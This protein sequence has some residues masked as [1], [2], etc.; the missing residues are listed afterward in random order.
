MNKY[1][2]IIFIGCL[3]YS[4][5]Q[6]NA[7]LTAVEKMAP[8]K[9]RN[10]FNEIKL[11]IEIDEKNLNVISQKKNIPIAILKQFIPDSILN[12]IN[13]KNNKSIYILPIGKIEK[14]SEWYLIL[15]FVYNSFK[16]V[17]VFAF[18]KKNKF[19]TSLL[20]N[21][22]HNK[23]QIGKY[24]VQINKEPTFNIKEKNKIKNAQNEMLGQSLAFI[25]KK[26][27]IVLKEFENPI[28]SKNKLENPID[29]FLDL[30]T[31]SADYF[32]DNQLLSLRDGSDKNSYTFYLKLN[33]DN[34]N[35]T[36]EITG[37][38]K[39]VNNMSQ[40]KAKGDPCGLSFKFNKDFIKIQEV[41]QC[42]SKRNF[43][44]NFNGIYYKKY[45]KKRLHL[46]FKLKKNNKSMK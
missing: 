38:I 39:L 37:D 23:K 21:Q 31:Y 29:T 40:F 43:V 17:Y 18:D 12:L 11:P 14:E 7:N 30:N 10:L 6:D 33:N 19:V 45:T 34:K 27:I 41:G 35:C 25:D 1:F 28:I 44:C 3:L 2:I 13:N 36:G 20:L 5:K 24:S 22:F 8:S 42:G 16:N 26:F 46:N 15:N 32:C 4:C 9:F